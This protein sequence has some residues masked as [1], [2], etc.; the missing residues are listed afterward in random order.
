M[1]GEYERGLK[2]YR[3]SEIDEEDCCGNSAPEHLYNPYAN[4]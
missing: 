2:R 1:I 4:A 3:R